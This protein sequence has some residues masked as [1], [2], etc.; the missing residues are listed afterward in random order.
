M[1]MTLC[2]I[3]QVVSGALVK[4]LVDTDETAMEILAALP[5]PTATGARLPIASV[6]RQRHG[7]SPHSNLHKQ[8]QPARCKST[9]P[10]RYRKQ[11]AALTN[12][13]GALC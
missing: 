5:V 10:R 1:K 13:L 6:S 9:D 11:S 4:E 12:P 8:I 3:Q 7:S 2:R